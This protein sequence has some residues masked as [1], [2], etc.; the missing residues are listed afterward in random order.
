MGI[1]LGRQTTT[2][3]RFLM[4]PEE[5]EKLEKWTMVMNLM[6]FDHE[7]LHPDHED[8]DNDDQ[9][10]LYETVELVTTIQQRMINPDKWM[11]A[12][13]R[14]IDM[15]VTASEIYNYQEHLDQVEQEQA[16]HELAVAE[17]TN[18][19]IVRVMDE[20]KFALVKHKR[21]VTH[22]NWQFVMPNGRV[23]TG[24]LFRTSWNQ[25]RIWLSWKDATGKSQRHKSDCASRD[26]GI[27]NTFPQN[28]REWYGYTNDPVRQAKIVTWIMATKRHKKL[29][30]PVVK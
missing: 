16:R 28:W 11:A 19:E 6:G 1:L 5:I 18:P 9:K 25:H 8:Y 24:R 23:V 27:P 3:G 7:S 29:N 2:I 10:N 4:T 26:F 12:A 14:T 30:F 21:Y 15:G 17:A 20:F 13:L 22:T